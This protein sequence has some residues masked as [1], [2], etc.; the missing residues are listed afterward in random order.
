MT[1]Y[2][3]EWGYFVREFAFQVYSIFRI[4]NVPEISN[5]V[6]KEER[7]KGRIVVFVC[8]CVSGRERRGWVD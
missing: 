2:F 3:R 5:L 7:M 6:I 4:R 8:V 1:S